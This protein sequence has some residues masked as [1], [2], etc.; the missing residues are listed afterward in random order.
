[1]TPLRK[2]QLQDLLNQKPAEPIDPQVVRVVL[3]ELLAEVGP[4]QPVDA[5]SRV[6]MP[7]TGGQ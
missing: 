4:T 1:M 5:V 7:K 2:K 3:R 6:S